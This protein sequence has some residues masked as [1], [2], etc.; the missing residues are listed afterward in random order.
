MISWVIFKAFR[1][2]WPVSWMLV[3]VPA[4]F[5]ASVLID[6]FE[7]GGFN[8]GPETI[9]TNYFNPSG[10]GCIANSR[11][12][13][14][15]AQGPSDNAAAKLEITSGDDGALYEFNALGGSLSSL[16]FVNTI[17]NGFPARDFTGG[18]T[19]E[20]LVFT[21]SETTA[22]ENSPMKLRYDASLGNG[23][24]KFITG[25]GTY[26]FPFEELPIP[27]A[28]ANS[29]ALNFLVFSQAVQQYSSMKVSH[30]QTYTAGP[31]PT[32]LTWNVDSLG[33]WSDSSSWDPSSG[34]PSAANHT[35][36]FGNLTSGP[37]TATLTD[38]VT[39]N[40]IEFNHVHPYAISGLFTVNL[41]TDPENPASLPT[42]NSAAGSH[43]FQAN[44][45][46]LADTTADVAAGSTLTFNNSLDLQGHTLSKTGDGEVA[47]NNKLTKGTGGSV[48]ILGGTISGSGTIGGSV[49]NSGGTTAP[50]NS[51]GALT[52]DGNYNQAS[53]GTLAIEIGGT[54]AGVEHDV[55]QVLGDA[56]LAGTLDVSFIDGFTPSGG[57]AF[58]VLTA[59]GE[60]TD[61]GLTLGGSAAES[62]T[63]SI[64][65]TNDWIMLMTAG[66][67]GGVPGD[68]NGNGTVDAA[69]YTIFRDNLGGDSAVLN[70]NGSG[71]ATIVQADYD[72]WKQNF[73]SSGTGSSAAV[74]EPSSVVLLLVGWLSVLATR[75]RA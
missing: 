57:N 75:R 58:I 41:A 1:L 10:A 34:T 71:A 12:I 27:S 51:P 60:L 38:D 69:D 46:I 54:Q 5:A 35:A 23:L 72:L 65:I 39:V 7:Q 22:T 4:T 53:G 47:I 3:A 63:M 67:G 50:G 21:V 43:Q 13:T 29:A 26:K 48:D 28:A 30:I 32:K 36:V 8:N 74:P 68:Y 73:G 11:F 42:L 18:G 44:V 45:N 6:D 56:S 24:Q 40:R 52:I 19:E 14:L 61:A 15:L 9:N 55:L 2:I 70:G 49:T 37:T 33:D 20:G 25:P 59:G 64:D 62:L 17:Y 66:G 31:P 16:S